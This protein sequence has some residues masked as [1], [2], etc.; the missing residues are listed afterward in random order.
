MGVDLRDG[1]QGDT[2][3]A[4]LAALFRFIVNIA[5]FL[6]ADGHKLCPQVHLASG[7]QLDSASDKDWQDLPSRISVAWSASL[8]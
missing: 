8:D 6:V 4:L 2:L 1:D 3:V 7:A 5:L